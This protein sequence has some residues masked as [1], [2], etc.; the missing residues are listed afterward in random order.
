MKT[1]TLTSIPSIS[2]GITF[3]TCIVWDLRIRITL[4]DFKTR[5]MTAF[6]QAKEKSNTFH[7][8]RSRIKGSSNMDRKSLS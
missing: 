8:F 5:S 3:F 6:L 2:Y 1:S 7:G 4:A